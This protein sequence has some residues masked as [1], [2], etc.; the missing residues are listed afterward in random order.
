M[1]LLHKSGNEKLDIIFGIT[2]Q[3]LV[4]SNIPLMILAKSFSREMYRADVTV[5]DLGRKHQLLNSYEITRSF[6]FSMIA[7][8]IIQCFVLSLQYM[9]R[10]KH[11]FFSEDES[12]E[13][14]FIVQIFF[15]KTK[16]DTIGMTNLDGKRIFQNPTQ[17]DYFE[18]MK[19]AWTQ[20]K[21]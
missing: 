15:P 11:Y 2:T 4:F 6:V 17:N 8:L 3:I 7:N 19:I 20:E 16:V 9:H 21:F 18:Q 12:A 13:M 5:Y 14:D 1:T 10:V